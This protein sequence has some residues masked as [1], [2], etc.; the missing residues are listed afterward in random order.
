[1]L[2]SAGRPV[3]LVPCAKGGTTIGRWTPAVDRTTLYGSCVARVREAGGQLTGMLCY[4]GESDA[5][6][7]PADADRWTAAFRQMATSFRQDLGKPNLPIVIVQIADR[8]RTDPDRYPSWIIIQAQQAQPP[9]P[10]TAI[11]SSRGLARN[12]DDLHLTTGAQQKLGP[13]LA[14][15]MARLIEQG[16]R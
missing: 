13:K 12:P 9:L 2:R 4:Q 6:K 7:P 5:E 8:P 11:V 14:A 15:A 16:C 3:A 1:M 10:C